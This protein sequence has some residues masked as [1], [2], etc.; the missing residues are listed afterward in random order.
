MHSQGKFFRRQNCSVSS[1]PC[2]DNKIA[3]CQSSTLCLDLMDLC[4]GKSAC[5]GGEDEDPRFCRSFPCPT[6]RPF[7]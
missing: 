5:P 1:D 7:R 3:R 6:D 4:D 2:P